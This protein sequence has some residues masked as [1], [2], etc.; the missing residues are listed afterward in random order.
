[1]RWFVLMMSLSGC[2]QIDAWQQQASDDADVD[3]DGW[4]ASLGDC[5]EN[6]DDQLQAPDGTPVCRGWFFHPMQAE[7]LEAL[8]L[9]PKLDQD[10]DGVLDSEQPGVDFDGDGFA[11]VPEAGDIRDC[12]DY[13]SNIRPG[14]AEA[15]GD[16]ID[17]DCDGRDAVCAEE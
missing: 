11:G 9:G 17:Q 12:D 13:N 3:R 6:C 8:S 5:D 2:Q 1:M 14:A 4:A 7:E 15:C 16:N 10:C